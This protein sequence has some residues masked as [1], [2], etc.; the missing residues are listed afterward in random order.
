VHWPRGISARGELR[1]DPGHVIDLVPT[2]RE[3]TGTHPLASAQASPAPSL[4]GL[5]LVPAFAGGGTVKHAELWWQ[6]EGNQ[7]IRVGDWKLVA[8]GND[9]P[10]ELYDL[11]TDRTETRDVSRQQPKRVR[12]LARRWQER[13][14]EFAALARRDL[15]LPSVPRTN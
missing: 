11:A 14:D 1:T 15:Q 10:W 12:E 13:R 2:I 5:S 4:A 3:L 9:A 8:A 7:A 6:H